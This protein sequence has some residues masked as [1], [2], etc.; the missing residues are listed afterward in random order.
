MKNGTKALEWWID[1]PIQPL[2]KVHIFNYTNH[3][4][5][6]K[7]PKNVKIEI[8]DLGPYVFREYSQKSKYNFVVSKLNK[9]FRFNIL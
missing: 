2:I 8:Q 7:D 5:V 3:N 6:L 1:S 4:E 9:F